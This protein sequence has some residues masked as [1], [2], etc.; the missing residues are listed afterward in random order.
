MVTEGGMDRKWFPDFVRVVNDF[1]FTNTQK[2][3]VRNLKAVHFDPARVKDKLWWRE[4]GDDR[5][6]PFTPADY[7]GLKKKFETAERL[8]LL[9]R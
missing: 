8:Q 4:R 9:E 6:R 2:I 7:A 5:F 1:E 3:L